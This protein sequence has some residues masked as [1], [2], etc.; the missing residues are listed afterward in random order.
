MT[1]ACPPLVFR[2]VSSTNWSTLLSARIT[3]RRMFGWTAATGAV[4]TSPLLQAQA[5]TG[6]R[7]GRRQPAPF[8]PIPATTAD[9]LVLAR[10]FARAVLLRWQDPLGDG[11]SFGNDPDFTA[12]FPIDLLDRGFDLARGH[13]GFAPSSA[14]SDEGLLVV[15]HEFFDPRFLH[16]A[17]WRDR[18]TPRIELEQTQVGLSVVR[19]VRKR[20]GWS[21][22]RDSRVTRR[23]DARSKMLLTGPAS[24]IDGGPWAVGTLANC[25]GGVT[26]WGT[27]LSCEENFHNFVDPILGWDPSVYGRRHY[28]W[29]VEVDPFDPGAIPRK[30]TALGRFRHE[31]VAI[32][33]AD[34]GTVVAYMGD[35]KRDSCVFKFVAERRLSD[36]RDRASN[37]TILERGRLYAADFANGRWLAIPSTPEALADACAAA[38]AA[39]A[40]PVDRPEDLEIDPVDGSVV[41]AMTNNSDHGNFHGHLVRL[42]E[43]RGEPAAMEF[44]WSIAA[45]GGPQSGFSCPDNLLFDGNGNLWMC[46]D[47]ADDAVSRGIYAFQGNNSMFFMPR[48]GDGRMHRFASGPVE[49]E[50][51]GPSFTPDQATMFLSVQHPGGESARLGEDGPSSH[52]PDGGNAMP[53]GAVVA[54]TGFGRH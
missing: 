10:G 35:D 52:W 22:V 39:G 14:S 43:R 29:I 51:T 47:V 5:S 41:I 32:R 54:I 34:D 17:S 18:T 23:Y 31:N 37:L 46:T 28:G 33:V 45:T 30:H 38:I 4:V 1:R 42:A 15:N 11:A 25:S 6:R 13:A 19:V 7:G 40:T 9:D 27:V 12:Y 3:R 16:G 2:T 48:E 49:C 36:P 44:K 24:A 21:V 8:T 50:L 20:E 26:P 53:R